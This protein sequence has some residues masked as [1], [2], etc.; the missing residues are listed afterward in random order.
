MTGPYSS[1]AGPSCIFCQ[2][3]EGSAPAYVVHEDAQTMS[4]LDIDPV[5]FGHT[6][7][8]P[9]RH[10]RTILDVDPEDA[11]AV[12][13]SAVHVARLLQ[14]SL[15][16]EGFSLFQANEAAGWQDVFHLHLHVIPRW[17]DD[18]L[19][20]PW[21]SSAGDPERLDQVADRLGISRRSG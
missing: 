11:A 14:A 3:V 20:P 8:V 21:R 19:V 9:R 5:T 1:E 12:M 16:P 10:S 17:R 18:G 15:E 6:L 2:I 13:R 4:F 7:V